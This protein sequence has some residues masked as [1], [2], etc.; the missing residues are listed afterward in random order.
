ML[1]TF[2][3]KFGTKVQS[4][5]IAFGPAIRQCCYKVGEEFRELFP[6]HYDGRGHVD[7]VGVIESQLVKRGV[8]PVQMYDSRLCT[9][10]S[11]HRFF[12]ARREQG[13]GERILAIIAIHPTV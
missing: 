10:C 1:Q 8:M 12:S 5:L 2:K 3:E 6:A 4:L 9:S 7:L 11:N 13:T